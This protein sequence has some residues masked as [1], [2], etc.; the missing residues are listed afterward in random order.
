MAL[1]AIPPARFWRGAGTLPEWPRRSCFSG[2][3]Q[4]GRPGQCAR[5]ARARYP[6]VAP[7]PARITEPVL[8]PTPSLGVYE[9]SARR[10]GARRSGSTCGTPAEADRT[11]H[12]KRVSCPVVT[13]GT[14]GA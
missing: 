3:V 7:S 6:F 12:A 1:V 8:R 5:R 4:V 2:G 9:L 11:A 14:V 10:R 13:A